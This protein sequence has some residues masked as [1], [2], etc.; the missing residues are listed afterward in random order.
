MIRRSTLDQIYDQAR[1]AGLH[2]AERLVT[3]LELPVRRGD[4]TALRLLYPMLVDTL[5]AERR[6]WLYASDPAAPGERPATGAT[7]R[8]RRAGRVPRRSGRR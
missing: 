6:R 8:E 5:A 7:G 3:V 1:A 2:T 4:V